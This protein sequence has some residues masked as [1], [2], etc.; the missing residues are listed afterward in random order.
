MAGREAATVFTM[1][2]D[3]DI[4]AARGVACKTVHVERVPA[5][6]EARHVP[7]SMTTQDAIVH[8]QITAA[9]LEQT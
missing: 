9:E 1:L 4:E 3:Q 7:V 5:L 6:L 2:L 8:G